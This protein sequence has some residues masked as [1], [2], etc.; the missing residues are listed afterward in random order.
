[1]RYSFAI[2]MAA[3]L[4]VPSAVAAQNSATSYLEK[5]GAGDLYER[6]SSR[7]ALAKSRDAAVR[8]F[9]QKMIDDHAKSTADLAASA[10]AADLKPASP[11]LSSAQQTMIAT[12]GPLSGAEFDRTYLD[13]QR[14]A[15]AE[16][17]SLHRTY[18]AGGD[19]PALRQTAAKIVPV[20]EHHIAMLKKDGKGS[21]S[22]HGATH[23]R[24]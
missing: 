14:K 3:T 6:D 10:K 2:I 19:Q 4:L 24:P 16:A 23:D 21:G 5:A 9:A 11:L 22:E 15:H 18:A 8:E 7:L 17:L 13:Q 20:I 12:L 1:M